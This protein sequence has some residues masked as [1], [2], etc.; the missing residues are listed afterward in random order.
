MSGR[1]PAAADRA[2][3]LGADEFA[4]LLDRLGPFE[5]RPRLAVAVSGGPDSMALARLARDWA[6]ARDG[7]LLALLV[8]HRLRPESAAECAKV[9]EWLHGRG[10][11]SRILTW[12]GDRPLTGIQAAARG[13]RYA[14][15]EAACRDQ[16]ILHLLVAHHFADQAETVALR[17]ARGSGGAGLAGMAAVREVRGLRLLRPL[18]AVPKARLVATLERERW[19]WL[20]DPSNVEPRFARVR[21]RLDN[22]FAAEVHW[23]RSRE[24]ALAR[25]VAEG[26]L[27]AWLARNAQPHAQGFVRLDA[28]AWLA[29]GCDRRGLVLGRVLQAVSGRPYPPSG[30]AMGRM[31]DDTGWTQRSLGGCLARLAKGA[32]LIQREPGRIR[33]RLR[34]GPGEEGWWDGRFLVRH[35]AGQP[36]VE[37]VALGADGVRALP[38]TLKQKLREAG[39]P[40]LALAGVPAARLAGELVACPTL[41][42]YG[43]VPRSGFR[44]T[45]ELRPAQPLAGPP[46]TGVNV[47]SKP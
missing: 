20:V 40:A 4:R 25:S 9:A 32:L 23:R 16:R 14:L 28:A 39:V 43:F 27:A 26:W 29:L 10:M 1:P 7:T 36:A 46:F 24:H 19:P 21:L 8:D 34:L 18:L 13:A 17:A 42:T 11:A 3:P 6:R 5:C 37:L 15:L 31:V 30:P 38:G 2:S 35:A 45:V 44:I 33:D 22:D 41:D 12:P 47:V